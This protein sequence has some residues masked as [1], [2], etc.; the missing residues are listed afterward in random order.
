MKAAHLLLGVALA[1]A[2]GVAQAQSADKS[3]KLSSYADG[4]GSHGNIA[5]PNLG[6]RMGQ[7]G[8]IHNLA[9]TAQNVGDPYDPFTQGGI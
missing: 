3:G 8:A 4:A 2:V 6:A 1:T 5:S 9:G 7:R